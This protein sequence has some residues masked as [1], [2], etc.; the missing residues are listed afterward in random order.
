MRKRDRI[1]SAV[2]CRMKKR[3]HK[4]GIKMPRNIQEDY[5]LDAVN[6]NTLWRD[7]I[8]KETKNASIAFDILETTVPPTRLY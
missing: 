2:N 7:A 1:I 8:R 3:T 4:Y 5:K 6:N